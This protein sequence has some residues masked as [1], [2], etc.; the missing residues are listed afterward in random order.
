MEA[1]CRKAGLQP[2][3]VDEVTSRVLASLVKAFTAFR[4]DPA[5]RFRGYLTRV[6]GNTISTYRKELRR[7]PVSVRFEHVLRAPVGS[8]LSRHRGGPTDV[9]DAPQTRRP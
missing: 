7:K 2:A 1:T 9:E 3:D 4:Y 8:G 5:K 6:I